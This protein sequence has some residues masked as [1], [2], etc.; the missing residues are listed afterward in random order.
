MMIVDIG[1]EDLKM[2]RDRISNGIQK[3][4]GGN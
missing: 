2:I 3:A 4:L 1:L